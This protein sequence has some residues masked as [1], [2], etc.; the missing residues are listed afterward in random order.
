MPRGRDRSKEKRQEYLRAVGLAGYVPAGPVQQRLRFLHDK[1]GVTFDVLAERTGMDRETVL[2]QYRGT[3]KAGQVIRSCHMATE[4]KILGAKFKP[5]DGAWFPAVGIRRRLQA[6]AVAGFTAPFLADR[7][8]VGDYRILHNTLSG[9]KSKGLVKAEFADAV[10]TLYDK[11]HDADPVEEGVLAQASSRC[12]NFAR[13]HGYAPPS[14]WDG[15]TIDD[16]EAEP[17]WTGRC[18]TWW[19]WHIHQR[20]G[21]PMCDRCAPHADSE[22]YP[23]FDGHRLRALRERKGYS[24]V[25]LADQVEG[26]N[27]STIQYWE[28]GRS[29]P[30]RQNKIDRVLSVLDATLEDVCE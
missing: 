29:K 26:I 27:A 25:R 1:R 17:E 2:M 12:R 8:P 19:G 24:R 23:G 9:R 5:G 11:L 15:D 20:D 18:G 14:C 16:P 22:P 13:R 10:I 6:L 4:R 7:L 21:I 30:V 28:D 3:N